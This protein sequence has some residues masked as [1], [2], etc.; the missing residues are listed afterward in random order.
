[1]EF[2]EERKEENQSLED[3]VRQKLSHFLNKAEDCD[4][5]DLYPLIL[6]QVEK[7]LIELTLER[8]AGNQLQAARMLGINRNTLRKKIQD[9]KIDHPS[10]LR[11]LRARS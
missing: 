3:I 8:S 10:R 6:Q 5:E 2:Q 4:L 1:M 9:L 7:P 11:R